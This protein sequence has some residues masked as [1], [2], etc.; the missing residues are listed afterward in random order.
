MT[1]AINTGTPDMLATL[2]A[3]VLTLTLN[4]PDARNAM[5]A[6][7]NL[8][9]QQQLASAEL[10]PAVKCIVLTGA[11]KGFCAGGDVKGMAAKGDGTVGAQTIDEA[12]A[13][14]RKSL[15]RHR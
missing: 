12:I 8:A 9:L 5:S 13:R 15:C 1:T 7:M 6:A 11:G 14:Q 3:G 4:R 10:D 2:D